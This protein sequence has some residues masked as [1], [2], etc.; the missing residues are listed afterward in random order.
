MAVGGGAMDSGSKGGGGFIG[1][2]LRDLVFWVFVADE[3][4]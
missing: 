1:V 3:D 4:S 2:F